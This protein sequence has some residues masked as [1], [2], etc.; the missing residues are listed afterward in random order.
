MSQAAT[1]TEPGWRP[2]PSGRYE[3]RYWDGGWTNRVANSAPTPPAAP[4]RRACARPGGAGAGRHPRREHHD[5][6]GGR[7]T[8]RERRARAAPIAWTPSPARRSATRHRRAAATPHRAA[9]VAARPWAVVVDFFRSFADQPESYHSPLARD[10]LPPTPG[11][12]GSSTPP[13]QLRPRRH[14]RAGRVSASSSAPTCP[15]LSGRDRH[16]QLRRGPASTTGLGL[17]YSIGAAALAVQRPAVGPDAGLPLADGHPVV[18]PRRAS[19]CAT[20]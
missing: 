12:S 19:W 5:R 7:A 2:D 6:D 9:R 8:T 14:H 11:A 15:W 10:P 20:C 17:G 13:G 16:R 3:W 18:R 4:P 1:P